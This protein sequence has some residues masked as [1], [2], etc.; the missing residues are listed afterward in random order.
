MEV[1]ACKAGQILN[2]HS[3]G[4]LLKNWAGNQGQQ[5]QLTILHRL[6]HSLYIQLK[7]FKNLQY[8]I[9]WTS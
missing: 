9:I 1:R 8:N 6:S 2:T 7:F 5:N 3:R 4:K